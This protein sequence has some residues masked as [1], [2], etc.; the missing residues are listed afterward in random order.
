MQLLVD[1]TAFNRSLYEFSG[2]KLVIR[3]FLS[4]LTNNLLSAPI[5]MHLFFYLTL[6]FI[7]IYGLNIYQFTLD[8][9]D[10]ATLRKEC[11]WSVVWIFGSKNNLR[12][13]EDLY[14]QIIVI[15]TYLYVFVQLKI[16]Y[17]SGRGSRLINNCKSNNWNFFPI[18]VN[19]SRK[20]TANN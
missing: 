20:G 10:S 3:W 2:G 1:E 18:S 12:S 14:L 5:G 15:C 6:V 16:Y 4:V 13:F 17:D 19:T 11:F 7:S 8:F 9:L